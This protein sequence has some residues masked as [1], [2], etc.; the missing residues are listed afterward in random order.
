MSQPCMCGATDC[1]RCYPGCDRPVECV[2]C[3]RLFASY[4]MRECKCGGPMCEECLDGHE[5]CGECRE[6][7]NE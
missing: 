2:E 3:G 7:D 1:P 4:S 6:A 5:M